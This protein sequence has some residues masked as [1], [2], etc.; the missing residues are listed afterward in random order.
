MVKATDFW[1]YLC[2][3]LD[4][5]FFAGIVCKGLKPLYDTMSPNFMHYIPAV[6]ERIAIGMCNGAQLAGVKSAVLMDF[7]NIYS[8][9]D[10][11]YNFS[12]IYKIPSLI[13]AYK[14]KDNKINLN[15]AGFNIQYNYLNKTLFKSDLKKFTELLEKDG[16]TGILIIREGILE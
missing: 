3:E 16:K 10:L 14:S 7:K 1:D 12:N 2:N 8:I 5:R 13:I 6:N 15:K 9:F 4:Y 11:S